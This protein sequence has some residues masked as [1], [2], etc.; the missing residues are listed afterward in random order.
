MSPV[1]DAEDDPVETVTDPV[2]PADSTDFTSTTPPLPPLTKTAPPSK[3]LA[4]PADR[5]KE[6]AVAPEPDE[7]LTAPVG[8]AAFPVLR[9][10]SP[11]LLP[12]D[13]PVSIV[14][15]PEFLPALPEL[16]LTFPLSATESGENKD[17]NPLSPIPL[18]PLATVTDPPG[19]DDEWPPMRT[20]SPPGAIPSRELPPAIETPPA[21]KPD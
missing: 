9:S 17:K 20:T 15:T 4:E 19:I 13:F 3:L 21:L 6:P 7:I 5:I 18:V 1:E 11:L 8:A 2:T 10:K 16:K 12:E 14:S